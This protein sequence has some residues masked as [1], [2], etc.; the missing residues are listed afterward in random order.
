[1][2]EA[3]NEDVEPGRLTTVTTSDREETAQ[4]I[5]SS[6][7]ITGARGYDSEGDPR[8]DSRNRQAM[9]RMQKTTEESQ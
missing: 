1:M 4:A 2:L 9:R 5:G 3:K 7:G 8:R 6:K